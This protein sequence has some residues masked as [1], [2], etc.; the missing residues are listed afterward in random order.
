MHM[1]ATFGEKTAYQHNY[2]TPTVKH[3]GKLRMNW[4][5]FAATGS[6]RLAITALTMYSY[7]A[8]G[9]HAQYSSKY[10]GEWTRFPPV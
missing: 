8:A 3:C 5:F 1:H 6:G 10:E 2:V 9:Q 7:H 4:A